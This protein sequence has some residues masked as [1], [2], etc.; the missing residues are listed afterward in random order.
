MAQLAID[1]P[2]DQ[3]TPAVLLASQRFF[4]R[5]LSWLAFN[6]RAEACRLAVAT[7]HFASVDRER[8]FGGRVAHLPHHVGR[9]LPHGE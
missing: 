7:V 5:E 8:Q 6:E 4:N 1:A 9:P 2:L 3:A